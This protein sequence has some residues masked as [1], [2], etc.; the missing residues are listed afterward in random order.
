MKSLTDLIFLSALALNL[1]VGLGLVMQ[2]VERRRKQTLLESYLRA[3]RLTA[4]NG[5]TGLHTVVH[6]VVKLGMTEDEIVAASFRSKRIFRMS[7][8]GCES[9]QTVEILLGYHEPPEP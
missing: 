8:A 7:P 3:E 4:A 9:S 1:L 2:R 6:L 5:R